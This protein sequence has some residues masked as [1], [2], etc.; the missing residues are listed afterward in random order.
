MKILESA[1]GTSLRVPRNAFQMALVRPNPL[2]QPL[3]PAVTVEKRAAAANVL[4][5][6]GL[7]YGSICA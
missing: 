1:T 2:P 4:T 7:M 3:K 5:K 6:V